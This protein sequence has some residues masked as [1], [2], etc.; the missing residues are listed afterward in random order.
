[1]YLNNYVVIVI[2][3]ITLSLSQLVTSIT[4]TTTTLAPIPPL[5]LGQARNV[6]EE[7][8]LIP[9][10]NISMYNITKTTTNGNNQTV[11]EADVPV[12]CFAGCQVPLTGYYTCNL[13]LDITQCLYTCNTPNFTLLSECFDCLIANGAPKENSTRVQA[14]LQGVVEF[15]KQNGVTLTGTAPITA[16]P[17]TTGPFTTTESGTAITLPW[18]NGSM[19]NT[20]TLGGTEIALS[21]SSIPQATSTTSAS[22]SSSSAPATSAAEPL[23]KSGMRYVGLCF[24]VGMSALSVFDLH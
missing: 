22:A 11:F 18:Y 6:K 17:T 14:E 5:G 1:M 21:P 23:L 3:F 20:L 4:I 7:N 12:V 19:T 13:K 10:Q 16:V 8:R 9:R 2:T 15:C 24:F